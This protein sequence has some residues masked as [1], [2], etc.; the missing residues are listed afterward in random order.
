MDEAES[1]DTNNVDMFDGDKVI[2]TNK[3]PDIYLDIKKDTAKLE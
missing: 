2:F 3:A 1:L